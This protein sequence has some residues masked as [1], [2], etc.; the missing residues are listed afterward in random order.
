MAISYF[1]N[2]LKQSK[3][4]AVVILSG[5]A[6]VGDPPVIDR[7][8]S[9]KVY[10]ESAEIQKKSLRIFRTDKTYV[11]KKRRQTG[12]QEKKRLIGLNTSRPSWQCVRGASLIG[13]NRR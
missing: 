4:I 10:K 1:R 12:W 3:F 11:V 7:S 9:Q 6:V 2:T 5:C 8:T 13:P